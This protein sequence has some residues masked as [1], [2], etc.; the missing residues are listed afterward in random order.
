MSRFSLAADAAA[1]DEAQR[2]IKA[3]AAELGGS[4]RWSTDVAAAVAE[5]VANAVEH[6]DPPPD[7]RASATPIDVTAIVEALP[8]GQRQVRI[9]VTDRGLWHTGGSAGGRG[10]AAM[11][12]LVDELIIVG[13]RQPTPGSI[14]ALVSRV[15]IDTG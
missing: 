13:G 6:G 8:A 2:A 5:A 7:Q 9:R 3:W 1:A 10:L 4:D 11:A 14:V 12:A 15:D